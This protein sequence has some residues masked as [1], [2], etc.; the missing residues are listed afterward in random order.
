MDNPNKE[1]ISKLNDLIQIAA[2][3]RDGYE[4]AA[5]NIEDP[6]A[7]ASFRQFA[8]ERATYVSQLQQEVIGL[9]GKPNESEGDIKGALHRTWLDIKGTFTGGDREAIINGCI[10][11]EESAVKSY[12]KSL[13]ED[14]ISG[15]TREI[16]SE[17]LSGIQNALNVIK[18][19]K[20]MP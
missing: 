17:Q 13:E 8:Q 4:K 1:A 6:N 5:E 2:D 19:L 7:K 20:D 10:T 3:G 12:E 11:G 15:K 16:V 14:S 18:S 9:N